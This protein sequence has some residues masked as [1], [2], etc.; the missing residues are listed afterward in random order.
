MYKEAVSSSSCLS[1][2][3]PEAVDFIAKI[4]DHMRDKEISYEN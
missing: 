3:K 2:S 4:T 1:L